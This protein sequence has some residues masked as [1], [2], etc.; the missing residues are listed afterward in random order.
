VADIDSVVAVNITANTATPSRTGFGTPLS[1]TYHARFTDRYRIYTDIAGM[2]ADGFVTTDRAYQAARAA[3][4][5]NPAPAS[6]VVGRLPV[7]PSFT[8]ALTITSAVEGAHVKVSVMSPTTGAVT[9]IDYTIL[10]AATTS[11]V[12]TAVE[13]LIE[14][15][16]GVDS[17]AVSAVITVTPTT[18]GTPVVM[19]DLT[20]CTLEETTADAGYDDELTALQLENDDWYFVTTD[21]ASETNVDLVSTWTEAQKKLYFV[22]TNSSSVLDGTSTMGSDLLALGRDRTVILWANNPSECAAMAWVGVGAPAEPGSITW[23]MKSLTSVTPKAL[24]ATQKAALE[25]DSV[26]HYQTVKGYNITRK[27]VVT[28][29]EFIDIIHGIDALEADIQESVFGLLAN[30]AKVPF[31]AGGLD[32]VANAI[33]GALKRFEGEQALLVPNTSVVL[34]P[35]LSAISTADKAARRLTGVRFSATLG[36]AIHYVSITGTLSL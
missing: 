12:A 2:A 36:G 14:A 19:Y 15:V 27:G 29:G 20:N 26:N 1:L 5:Q 22:T 8:H 23:A 34:M 16:A 18:A 17:A 33:L 3:F 25:A 6:I 10:A 4:S 24:T 35:E 28:S 30:S 31:T 13:A 21:S 32:L 7:A 11:T 9:A